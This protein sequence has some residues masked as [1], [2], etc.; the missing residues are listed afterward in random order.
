MELKLNRENL[1]YY[2]VVEEAAFSFETTQEAIV[3]DS[4]PDVARVV[5]TAGQVLIQS[6]EI[7]MEGRMEISGAVKAAV[8]F[9]PE[10]AAGASVLHLTMP[11]RTYCDGKGLEGCGHCGLRASLKSLDTRML[12]PRKLLLRA[13]ISLEPTG[14]RAQAAAVCTGLEEGEGIQVLEEENSCALLME[15]IEKEFTFTE[16]LQIPASR[17]GVRELLTGQVAVKP[18]ELKIVGRKLVVKGVVLAEILYRSQADELCTLSQEY[19]F[20]QILETRADEDQ[21]EARAAFELVD[22]A[23]QVGG[24]QRGDDE[25]TVTMRLELRT[26]AEVYE[27]RTMRCLADLYSLS[28]AV[29]L[30]TQALTLPEDL[31]AYTRKYN[32]RE[33]VETGVAVKQ[34][35]C[36]Q[37]RCGS[38]SLT[39]DGGAVTAQAPAILRVLYCDEG[40]SLL[41]A[42]R[43]VI[44]SADLE[45]AEDAGARI[46]ADCAGEIQCVTTSDGVE[47]RFPATFL[48]ETCRRRERLYIREAAWEEESEEGTQ[49]SVVLERLPAGARLWDV[50]KRRHSTCADILAANGLEKEEDIDGE[51]LLLIPRRRA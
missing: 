9:V 51:R 49:P 26:V 36:G 8:L 24:E 1:Q 34:V 22:C 11:F 45:L 13:D 42:E 29:K 43:E 48:V 7:G 33:T 31:S 27:R 3:P 25:Y 44:L 40:G 10:G 46:Q 37:V 39:R 41:S 30:E 14:Y 18:T 35:I 12:N 5:D 47:L 17:K 32:V 6:R 21:G 50:A 19:A 16:E 2:E 4:C 38:V 23:F 15:V 28:G 20:S